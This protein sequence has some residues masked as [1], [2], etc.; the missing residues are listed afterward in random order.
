MLSLLNLLIATN[1][2]LPEIR[3][4]LLISL[5]PFSF[6]QREEKM[7]KINNKADSI[8]IVIHEIY[9]I[10]PPIESYCKLLSEQNFDV[11][12]P[13]LIK[14]IIPYYYSQEEKAYHNFIENIGFENAVKT[15]QNLIVELKNDYNNIFII[16]FSVGATVAWLCSELKYLNAIVGYYSSRIRNYLDIQPKCPLK[17]SF[18]LKKNH[19]S[20]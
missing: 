8:V 3:S 4:L 12:C 16:G 5:Y 14:Q 7:I 17:C 20:V 1:F 19:P 9:G 10:N 11:L 2:P 18:S 15:I 13:N 6:V